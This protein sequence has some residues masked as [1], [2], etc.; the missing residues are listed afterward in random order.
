MVIAFLSR[1]VDPL[2]PHQ[3][4]PRQDVGKMGPKRPPTS[5]GGQHEARRERPDAER[6]GQD[7]VEAQG[8]LPAMDDASHYTDETQQRD[9]YKCI[10]VNIYTY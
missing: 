1:N 10:Y 8:R 4:I 5:A 3:R 6:Q 7:Q 2:D 9:D